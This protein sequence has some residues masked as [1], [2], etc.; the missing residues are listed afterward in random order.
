MD[1]SIDFP[2]LPKEQQRA[3][4]KR[5]KKIPTIPRS[6]I[7]SLE[8]DL[9]ILESEVQMNIWEWL[10][11]LGLFPIKFE[12]Q[13]TFDPRTGMRRKIIGGT[14]RKGVSDLFFTVGGRLRV[15]EVK[16]PDEYAYI[17]RNWDK[18]RVHV[19]TP[20][21]PKVKGEKQKKVNDKKL[22]YQEQ[23]FFIDKMT[24]I[25]HGGFFADS[26]ERVAIELMKEPHLLSPLQFQE[27][28]RLAT[29]QV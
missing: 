29:P 9:P 4:I 23:M 16:T 11:R 26:V 6:M 27:C 13:G 1:L 21:P 24:E 15:C 18:I 10:E 7:Q 20:P 5:L 17:M 3:Y 12:S 19:P 28:S 25:G 2:R 22:H 14:K 8:A